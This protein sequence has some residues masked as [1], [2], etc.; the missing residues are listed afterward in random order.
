MGNEKEQDELD[1]EYE[2]NTGID[3]N[4][5]DDN[6]EENIE[7]LNLDDIS[8]ID[9]KGIDEVNG[10]KLND[11]KAVKMKR[12]IVKASFSGPL[13]HPGILRGYDEVCP[14][15]ADRIIK[16]AEDQMHHRQNMEKNFLHSNSRNSLLGIVFAFILGIVIIIGGI[17]CV[18]IGKQVSGLIFGGA[19]LSTII[20]AF[21]RGTRMSIGEMKS[22]NDTEDKE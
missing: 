16:M 15:A 22:K 17:Y 8:E 9:I 19:G 7:E 1:K 3:N 18:A 21:I 5:I 10:C 20:I 4:G 2:D 12:K 11:V 14:G 13:P 6:Q